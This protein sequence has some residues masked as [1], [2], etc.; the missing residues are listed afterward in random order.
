M[1][2]TRVRAFLCLVRPFT[3]LAPA[4]GFLS[5]ATMAAGR[6]PPSPALV[7]ALAAALLNAASNA[8]NQYFDVEIDRINKPSRPLP[9]DRL[10]LREAAILSGL[11]YATALCLAYLAHPRLLAIFVPTAMLTFLYS[12]PP[13]RLRRHALSASFALGIGR[14]C[15]LM[16]AGWMAVQPIW[17]PVP[18]FVGC[19]FGLYIFGAGNTKDFADVRGDRAYGIRTLPVLFGARRA[20]LMI[21]PF[22]MGPFLLVP[23]GVLLGWVPEVGM[24]LTILAV[25]GGYIGWL[26]L[27]RPEALTIESNH[28]SWKHMYLLLIAGQVGFAWVYVL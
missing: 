5:G 26:M 27:R 11:L 15:L 17:N 2:M 6:L 22:L 23:V 14:G 9:S 20:A 13:I 12:A 1:D 24:W 8:V 18:W 7:G 25:W 16:V 10:S 19:V 4:L 3:L 21:V 28:I